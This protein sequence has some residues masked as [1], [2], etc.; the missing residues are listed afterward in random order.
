MTHRIKR[1]QNIDMVQ[2]MKIKKSFYFNESLVN[3]WKPFPL[4]E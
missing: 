2:N 3:L 1:D 4:N